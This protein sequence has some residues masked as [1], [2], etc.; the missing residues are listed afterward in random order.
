MAASPTA[1]TASNSCGTS[2]AATGR[3]TSSPLATAGASSRRPPRRRRRRR[4][5]RCSL[6]SAVSPGRGAS[7]SSASSATVTAAASTTSSSGSSN[8]SGG[9][10]CCTGT[11]RSDALAARTRSM[12]TS[13]GSRLSS[14][15]NATFMPC[16]TSISAS[17]TRLWFRTY[18]AM[19]PATCTTISAARRLPPSSSTARST[20][21]AALSVLRMVPVPV[22][23]GQVTKLVSARDGRRRCRLISSRPKWLMEPSW[24]R[25]RSF[26]S[27][28]FSF[29]ST[30]A[31][32]RRL[33]MSMK[34]MTINPARSRR[35]NCRAASSAAS[36]LVRSAVSSMP[37]SRVL[38]PEFT[39]M[40]T[41]ASVWLM[42]R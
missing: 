15:A 35:R 12:R 22:Q 23:C 1:S 37:R 26:F 27:A 33:S 2:A 28:S 9:A 14:A 17:R 11:G 40:A 3:G 24:M 32:L 13:G 8:G 5:P 30:A 31:L 10:S 20:C 36:M 16:R 7:S 29:F 42:T 41:S 19:A 4:L 18:S 6:S 21:S 34:S 39:S 38:R 25:A